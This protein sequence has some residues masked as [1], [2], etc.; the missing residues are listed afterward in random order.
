VTER[1]RRNPTC[2]DCGAPTPGAW[3]PECG[4]RNADPRAPVPALVG[5]LVAESLSLDSRMGRTAWPLF[6]RPGFLT[7]E[8]A[9]GRRTRYSSPVRMYLLTSLLF[10]LCASLGYDRREV[11]ISAGDAGRASAEVEEA[12]GSL[13]KLGAVGRYVAER[14]ATLQRL[15]LEEARRRISDTF[16]ANVPRVAF[17]LVP[18]MALLLAAAYRGERRYFAEHAVFSLH[19]HAFAFVVFTPVALLGGRGQPVALAALV[20]HLALAL[21]RVHGGGWWRTALVLAALLLGYAAA[22]AAGVV[23]VA[24]VSVALL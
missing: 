17:F 2:L 21:R 23:A 4:Q 22:L 11:G 10:F 3:C 15:G 6:A 13:E 8:W 24:I 16:Q 7:A 9:A 18:W 12:R 20:A 19:A 1:L 5:E 14:I